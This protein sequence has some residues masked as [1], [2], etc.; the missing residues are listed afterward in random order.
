MR[1]AALAMKRRLRA[2]AGPLGWNALSRTFA[3]RA[4]REPGW[5]FTDAR[6]RSSRARILNMQ[7]RHQGETC[8]II[9]GGRSLLHTDLASLQGRLSIGLNR[10][11]LGFARF[12]FTPTY[13]MCVNELMMAQW[14]DEFARL[15]MPL[16]TSWSSRKHAPAKA[17]F[18]RTR[19]GTA[20][21]DAPANHVNVGGTVTFVAL[22]LALWMG[23]QEAVLVGI[24]HD[25]AY[26]DNERGQAANTTVERIAAD[27]NHFSDQYFGK[28]SQW[29]L[30]DLESS[31]IAYRAARQAYE[32]AGKTIYDAT[33]GGKLDIFPKR[34]LATF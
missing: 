2:L 22:Q 13:M 27:N 3:Y 28:G 23:V 9:G 6:A 10:L 15:Q 8:F 7:N 21:S 25:Y 12:A 24:D 16:F 18:M 19:E 4:L 17:I 33:P 31:E 32:E 14:G 29:Q 34:D 26:L 30:P 11:Y 5:H 1:F 20:F